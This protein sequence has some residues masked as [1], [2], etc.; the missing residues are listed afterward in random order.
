M[1]KSCQLTVGNIYL[2]EKIQ[3]KKEKNIMKILKKVFL[4]FIIRKKQQNCYVFEEHVEYITNNNNLLIN[5]IKSLSELSC[6][7]SSKFS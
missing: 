1:M 2:I 6:T 4:I 7:N 3:K 5:F